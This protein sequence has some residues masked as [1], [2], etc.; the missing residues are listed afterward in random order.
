MSPGFI[1]QSMVKGIG[2]RVQR[3]KGHFC[4]PSY[5][6]LVEYASCKE[7]LKGLLDFKQKEYEEGGCVQ[8]QGVW[9]CCQLHSWSPLVLCADMQFMDI[10]LTRNAAFQTSPGCV[11]TFY[12][13]VH[14]LVCLPLFT[15]V[16]LP[17]YLSLG[18]T[19]FL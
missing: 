8:R 4:D 14:L 6:F 3:F 17:V 9:S 10:D 11:G 18:H 15:C 2:C 16:C 19:H 13:Q 12:L 1:E 7:N 5:F